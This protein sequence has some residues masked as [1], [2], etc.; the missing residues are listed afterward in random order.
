MDY[1]QK[2]MEYCKLKYT[3]E[4]SQKLCN[5]YCIRI[6]KEKIEKEKEKEKLKMNFENYVNPSGHPPSSY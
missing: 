2:C 1:P 3:T 6:F 5:E 4:H